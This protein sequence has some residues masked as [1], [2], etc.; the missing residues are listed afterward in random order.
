MSHR[1]RTY[2]C[3]LTNLICLER[4]SIAA[5]LGYLIFAALSVLIPGLLIREGCCRRLSKT[6]QIRLL[7]LANYLWTSR[8]VSICCER[9]RVQKPWI[10][11]LWKPDR[12]KGSRKWGIWVHPGRRRRRTADCSCSWPG[13]AGALSRPC[14]ATSLQVRTCL[15]PRQRRSIWKS[16]GHR[17]LDG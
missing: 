6:Y 13:A 16:E 11:S 10:R 1:P 9:D 17:H 2:C 4:D 7:Y 12:L 15:R 5:R 8:R 3:T 14:N